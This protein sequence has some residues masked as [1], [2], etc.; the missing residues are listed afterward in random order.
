MSCEISNGNGLHIKVTMPEKT[1]F[2]IIKLVSGDGF[3]KQ[4]WSHQYFNVGHHY[5]GTGIFIGILKL[6]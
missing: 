5:K 3:G 2:S 6:L 4:H 1:L